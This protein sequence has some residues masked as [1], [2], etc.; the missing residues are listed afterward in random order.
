MPGGV[1]AIVSFC[2]ACGGPTV[3]RELDQH[4]R[5]VCSRCSKIHYRK[6]APASGCV[7]EH[8]SEVL[9]ARRKF[10]P[11]KGH[12]YIPSG[13]VEYGEDVEE[14]ARREIRGE[15][16]LARR[17]RTTLW[18]LVLRQ[19]ATARHHHSVSC[20]CRR[21]HAAGGRRR[22]RGCVLRCR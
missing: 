4:L 21:R 15:T 1:V 5:S 20:G 18:R 16:G 6:A 17:A 11:W 7:V 9:L 8:H 3:E 13:F 14:T 12:W 10:E 19:S 2:T 22:G